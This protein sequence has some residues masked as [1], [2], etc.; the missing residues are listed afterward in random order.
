MDKIDIVIRWVDDKDTDWQKEKEKYKRLDQG[1]PLNENEL[2]DASDIRYRDWDLLKYWFR[3]IEKYAPWVNKVF[4]VSC[5]QIPEWLNKD[6]PKIRIVHHRDF[7]PEEWLPTFSS[8]TIDLNLFRIPDLSEQFVLFDDD[9]FVIK[10]THATDFFVNGLPCDSM[11]F[12]ALS[13]SYEDVISINLFNNMAVIN[14]HF[15][16]S[17]FSKSERIKMWFPLKYHKFLYKNIVLSPWT[18]YSGFQDFHI[19]EGLLKQAYREIWDKESKLLSETCSHKFRKSQDVTQW[20]IRYWQLASK[21]FV[22]RSTKVGSYY[23]LSDNNSQ[24][25][26]SIIKQKKK[27]LCINEGYVSD[28]EGERNKL[29]SAF[30]CI[31]PDKSTFEI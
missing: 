19:P 6:H 29:Q 8:R 13:A 3:G 17:A 11:V 5:G 16:K 26:D 21:R 15:M 2:F 23:E 27:L 31:F 12:N 4:F 10:E 28:F 7:I 9:M 24:V 22:P 18:Y 25:I 30:S 20:L 1:L 14:K